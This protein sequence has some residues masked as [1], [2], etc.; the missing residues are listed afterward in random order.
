MPQVTE[1]VLALVQELSYEMTGTIGSAIGN[2]ELAFE[3]GDQGK[4]Q[5]DRA[6]K[7]CIR[8]IE[9]SRKLLAVT[10]NLRA[11]VIA[12][13]KTGPEVNSASV[14]S[15]EAGEGCAAN[16]AKTPNF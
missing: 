13:M 9:Q 3:R 10:S 5:L 2:M 11:C 4:K 6:R 7:L 12:F 15:A 16:S 1:Q 8:C 14:S